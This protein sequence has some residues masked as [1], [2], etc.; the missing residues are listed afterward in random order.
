MAISLSTLRRGA[1]HRPPRI[2]IH[3]PHKIG[4]S[5]WAAGTNK[6]V[7]MCVEEG[8]DELNVPSWP[9]TSEAEM[10]EALGVLITE[11]HEF[12]T[13]VIDT[14][15]WLEERIHSAIAT[16]YHCPSIAGTGVQNDPLGYGKGYKLAVS[17]WSQLLEGLDLLRNEKHMTIIMLAHSRVQ[18]FDDPTSAS[19]DRYE[20]NLQGDQAKMKGSS[21][22]LAEWC[23]VLGFMS[24]MVS[25]DKQDVGFNRKIVRGKGGSDR[26]L[27][28][29]ERP[30]FVAG[31]RYGLPDSIMIP[32]QGGW[33]AFETELTKAMKGNGKDG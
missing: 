22:L 1:Q 31:N 20:L 3:G 4:K 12:Q 18:R 7:F 10:L 16:E 2:L 28:L 30:A 21:S 11:D 23:D 25:A 13:L 15:D 33:S 8:A 26:W 14:V 19:Y 5:T 17:R 27:F 6:P 9:I 29:E 24:R 32:R